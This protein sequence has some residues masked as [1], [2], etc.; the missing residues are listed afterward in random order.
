MW[1]EK[2]VNWVELNFNDVDVV[3]VVVEERK[4][5]VGRSPL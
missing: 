5:F 4:M 3:V 2:G 1:R